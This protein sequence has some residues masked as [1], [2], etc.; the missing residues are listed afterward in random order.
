MSCLQY[1]QAEKP[2]LVHSLVRSGLIGPEQACIAA[3]SGMRSERERSERRT[4]NEGNTLERETG[5]EPATLSLGSVSRNRALCVLRTLRR[6]P[7]RNARNTQA[8]RQPERQPGMSSRQVISGQ[9][10]GVARQAFEQKLFQVSTSIDNCTDH[11]DVFS[12][13]VHDAIGSDDKFPP[14]PS[15][16]RRQFRHDASSLRRSPQRVCS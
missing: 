10:S 5:F 3:S 7:E 15:A 4:E 2:E 1:C 14:H 12:N 8:D 16:R 6:C 11:H 9:E 13:P